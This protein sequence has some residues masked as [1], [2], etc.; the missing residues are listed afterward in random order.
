[1]ARRYADLFT[2]ARNDFDLPTRPFTADSG[3]FGSRL[4]HCYS[5]VRCEGTNYT[6]GDEVRIARFHSS[7]R[8]I[9]CYISANTVSRLGIIN[10]GYYL[11]GVNGD[12]A[13]VDVDQPDATATLG[14]GV[15]TG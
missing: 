12:G 8:M 13:V 3:R 1:M 7:D 9:R 14:E 5:E 15:Q 2:G 6:N 4:R 10:V 11:S